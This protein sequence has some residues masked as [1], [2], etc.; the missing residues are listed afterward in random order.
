VLAAAGAAH[1]HVVSYDDH[2]YMRMFV[3]LVLLLLLGL[4]G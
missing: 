4:D 2:G 3:L 1:L